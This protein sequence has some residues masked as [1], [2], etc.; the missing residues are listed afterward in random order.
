MASRTGGG[1]SGGS[2]YVGGWGP[3][4]R[5]WWVAGVLVVVVGG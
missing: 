3:G 4:G 1:D 5:G 2:R